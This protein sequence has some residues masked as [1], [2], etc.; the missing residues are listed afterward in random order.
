V[1]VTGKMQSAAAS[2][3]VGVQVRIPLRD[4]LASRTGEV[5]RGVPASSR[6]LNARPN[7]SERLG[8]ALGAIGHAIRSR[9]RR[10]RC[11]TREWP[12][13]RVDI[14]VGRLHT[15][16]TAVVPARWSSEGLGPAL[17]TRCS[18]RSNAWRGV[19]VVRACV[20][21]RELAGQLVDFAV[22]GRQII[23]SG[24]RTCTPTPEMQLPIAFPVSCTTS[25]EGGSML[26]QSRSGVCH[27][28]FPNGALAE[29]ASAASALCLEL[30]GV[31][32]RRQLACSSVAIREDAVRANH[33][34]PRI[35]RQIPASF[36]LAVSARSRRF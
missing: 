10:S 15:E 5:I 3:G 7:N 32:C 25:P 19:A 28:E 29:A 2:S 33:G 14:V 1:Q 23:R 12:Y 36:A 13:R 11:R 35:K 18:R 24:I 16:S 21:A 8:Q 22:G 34:P 31:S 9:R 6:A 26:C 30:L 27:D 4:D 20:S 17:C